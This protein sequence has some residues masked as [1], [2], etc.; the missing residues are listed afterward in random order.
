[1]FAKNKHPQKHK[2]IPTPHK[3]KAQKKSKVCFGLM[4]NIRCW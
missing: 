1:M 2:T 3:P 4:S